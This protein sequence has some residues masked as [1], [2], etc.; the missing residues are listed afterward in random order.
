MNL[1]YR[2]STLNGSSPRNGRGSGSITG[3]LSGGYRGRRSSPKVLASRLWPLGDLGYRAGPTDVCALVESRHHT[4]FLCCAS[5][6][7][8]VK[9][10]GFLF[11]F[12]H[13]ER[14]A[15]ALPSSRPLVSMVNSMGPTIFRLFNLL[16]FTCFILYVTCCPRP[17]P[18]DPLEPPHIYHPSDQRS[19]FLTP[20][21]PPGLN[22]LHRR[23]KK[24][25]LMCNNITTL[26]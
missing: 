13:D 7:C 2:P 9:E 16:P 3:K 18:S 25:I 10:D 23:R 19:P 8:G 11:P 5:V 4:Y 22:Q 15:L 20:P 17:S 1:R 12:S 26:A 24:F 14:S 21:S 6:V